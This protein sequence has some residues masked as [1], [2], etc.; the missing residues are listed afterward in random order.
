MRPHA[1]SVDRLRIAWDERLGHLVRGWLPWRPEPRTASTGR[2]GGARARLDV[3]CRAGADLPDPVPAGDAHLRLGR[4]RARIRPA[5]REVLISAEKE[6][7]GALVDLAGRRAR[8]EAGP[9]RTPARRLRDAASS[10]LTVASA[11]LL[12]RVDRL[13]LHAGAVVAPSGQAWLLAGDA[14]SGKSSTCAT[15]LAAGWALVSDDQ[16]I[17]GRDEAAGRPE[18]VGWPRA[19]HLDPGW[20]SCVPVGRRWSVDP[21]ILGPRDP[22]ARA[23]AAGVIALRLAPE[24]PTA[25]RRIPAAEGLTALLRQSPW[26]MAD[27]ERAPVLLERLREVAAAG[28]FELRLGED[29]FGKPRRLSG[30]LRPLTEERG[31]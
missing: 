8:V 13:L 5:A 23:P 27:R 4:A 12:G 15:L 3:L 16:V 1:R 24:A 30:A 2:R 14:W 18:V 19:F 29:S 25:L 7:L 20:W 11:F 9:W 22:V 31:L 26:L 17:L 21:G 6:E 10:V 28:S